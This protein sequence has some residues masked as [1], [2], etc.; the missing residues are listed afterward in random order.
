LC[1]F[2]RIIN[3]LLKKIIDASSLYISEWVTSILFVRCVR[4]HLVVEFAFLSYLEAPP[5]PLSLGVMRDGGWQAACRWWSFFSP[6]FISPTW[7]S[8]RLS[9]LFFGFSILI[10]IFFIFDFC[11][12][13]FYK[14]F[15]CFQFSLSIIICHRLYFSFFVLIFFI[16]NFFLRFFC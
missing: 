13:S 7:K 15:V 11:F 2:C 14:S 3:F 8:A 5:C 12:N 9:S 16:S 10:L 1:F 4:H 6:F